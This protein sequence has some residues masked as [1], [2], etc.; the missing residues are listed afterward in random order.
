MIT[1]QILLKKMISTIKGNYKGYRQATIE[2]ANLAVNNFD[3]MKN[4]KPPKFSISIFSPLLPFYF[5]RFL[6][7]HV[8]DL[9]RK[10]TPAEKA[11]KKMIKSSKLK[12]NA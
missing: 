11:L 3:K 10:K 12:L 6:R 4:V 8:T 5:L 2:H 9:F 7:I 1:M